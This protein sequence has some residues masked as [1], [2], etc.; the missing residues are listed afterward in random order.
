MDQNDPL[1]HS[2]E[3]GFVE[4]RG[5]RY[6]ALTDPR[7]HY[8]ASSI[9]AD[10][11]AWSPE[12]QAYIMPTDL[13]EDFERA[14]ERIASMPWRPLDDNMARYCS[15]DLY[16]MGIMSIQKPVFADN[17]NGPK[18]K[19]YVAP[20][21]E[22]FE[23]AN[24]LIFSASRITPEQIAK[25]NGYIASG[26]AAPTI[27]DGTPQEF[28]AKLEARALSQTDAKKILRHLEPAPEQA[29]EEFRKMIVDGRLTEKTLGFDPNAE[30]E[31]VNGLKAQHVY[32]FINDGKKMADNELKKKVAAYQNL[33]AFGSQEIYYD[34]LSSSKARS[35]IRTGQIFAS[36]DEFSKALEEV[37]RTGFGLAGERG[38]YGQRN[39]ANG[40]DQGAFEG[41]LDR[42]TSLLKNGD[43]EGLAPSAQAVDF[44]THG[45]AAGGVAWASAH[46]AILAIDEK[47]YLAVNR[48]DV[49]LEKGLDLRDHVG[50]HVAFAC[51]RNDRPYGVLTNA[52]SVGQAIC[53]MDARQTLHDTRRTFTAAETPTNPVQGKVIA[54]RGDFASL[55]LGDAGILTVAKADLTDPAPK[56]N[57]TV[58]FEP[59]TVGATA[60]APARTRAT[61]RSR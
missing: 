29:I 20:N 34:D 54:M 59:A 56:Y 40:T 39:S 26:E 3:S 4:V 9:K 1:Y 28:A 14:C 50:E 58:G 24:D 43:I 12:H 52:N 10:G 30:P 53:E 36:G 18:K 61:S 60:A 25:I 11:G 17:P 21:E 15:D 19:V 37:D 31:R 44:P 49:A 2:T 46:H 6:Y 42:M 51:R 41:S 23:K 47:H 13:T 5:N 22:L 57:A 33:G 55:D 32:D 38:A 7:S 45:Y 27:L 8:F 16:K 35:L 48:K